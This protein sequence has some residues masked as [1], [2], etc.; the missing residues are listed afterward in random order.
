MYG[1]QRKSLHS[2]PSSLLEKQ[3][4]DRRDKDGPLDNECSGDGPN[5]EIGNSRNH[6]WIWLIRY[7]KRKLKDRRAKKQN[8]STIDR[9]AR[10]TATATIWMAFLTLMLAVISGGG[11]WI[12][13]K[14]LKEVQSSGTQTA[15]TISS[16]KSQAASLDGQLG[17][18]KESNNTAR[19]TLIANS[20]AWIG[21]QSASSIAPVADTDLVVSVPYINTGR[22]PAMNLT[23][24]INGF[25]LPE[26]DT[27]NA[28]AKITN[29]QY[30]CISG[31]RNNLGVAY[32]SSGFSTYTLRTTIAKSAITAQAIESQNIFYVVG[33]FGYET[34]SI[35]RYSNFCMFYSPKLSKPETWNFCAV[36]NTAY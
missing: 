30:S 23:Y 6:W 13:Y 11:I 31:A 29:V 4:I 25:I 27:A 10:K 34:F 20:R 16:L 26:K 17:Q 3:V 32:P 15:E 35:A 36:G 22:Q 7:T 33:C 12:S 18:L 21:I 14:T 1:V 24:A 2:Q 28:L 19:E 8:E 9:A 5:D